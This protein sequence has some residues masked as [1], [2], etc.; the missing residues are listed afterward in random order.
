[1][2]YGTSNLTYDDLGNPLT[3]GTF[4]YTWQNGRQLARVGYTGSSTEYLYEYN[5]SGIRT[6]KEV[7]GVK[8]VYTLN[9]SQIVTESWVQNGLEYFI[10]YLYDE[11]GAP[12]GMQYRT[13]NYAWGEFDNFFFEK[14]LFGDIVAVYNESGTKLITYTYDAWGNHE[15]NELNV[16]GSNAAARYNPFRYRGYYFDTETGFYYLQSRYYNPQWGRFL[17][18]DGLAY[19]GANEDLFAYN[20][21]VYGSNNPIMHTDPSGTLNWYNIAVAAG[22]VL[23][24]TALV[25]ASVA[26]LG[27]A[28]VAA[29]LVTSTVVTAAVAGSVIGGV[30]AGTAAI[31]G[32]VNENGSDNM[33]FGAIALQTGTGAVMGA[34]DGFLGSNISTNLRIVGQAG[35]IFASGASS[36]VIS[37]YEGNSIGSSINNSAYP[38]L[39]TT[40]IG[41]VTSQSTKN[42][43]SLMP[44][45][46]HYGVKAGLITAGTRAALSYKSY[47]L[48]DVWESVK[49]MANEFLD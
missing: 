24:T 41:I 3:Y 39:F 6:S 21:Y 18:Q 42:S 27:G 26:T 20:L 33:D 25:A 38:M 45:P 17:N 47:V 11:S 44:N 16:V 30:A 14:N 10:V 12:I 29:G 36:Y 8:H 31:V 34:I 19:L 4:T 28:A 22:V 46:E 40:T 43:A 9:G 5:D 2:S 48:D 13:S 7:N 49:E 32:E 1:M 35:R 15:P 37:R 23:A